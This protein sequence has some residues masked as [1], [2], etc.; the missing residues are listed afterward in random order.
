MDDPF[1]AADKPPQIE[2][3]PFKGMANHTQKF[4]LNSTKSQ[5]LHTKF[6]PSLTTMKGGNT[7]SEE[8]FKPKLIPRPMTAKERRKKLEEAEAESDNS[9][10]PKQRAYKK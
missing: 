7:V 5:S 6:I 2:Y 3:I 1:S 10:T 4:T 8:M 9:D